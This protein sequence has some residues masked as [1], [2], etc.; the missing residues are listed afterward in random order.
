MITM[1]ERKIERRKNRMETARRLWAELQYML[2]V[3][4]A[5]VIIYLVF[6]SI[7]RIVCFFVTVIPL[8]RVSICI[9][10]F[11]ISAKC[12]RVV[13]ASKAFNRNVQNPK[14]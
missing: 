7:F 11:Y 13:A 10:L 1:N 6:Y 9:I 14:N 12:T 4:L 2:G 8:I 5:Y 3:M